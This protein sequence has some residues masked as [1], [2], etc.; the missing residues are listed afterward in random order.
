LLLTGFAVI[1]IVLDTTVGN[2]CHFDT[3]KVVGFL[4]P[5]L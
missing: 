4:G 3:P 5:F 1:G 2:L